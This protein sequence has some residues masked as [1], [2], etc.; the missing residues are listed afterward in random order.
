[1]MLLLLAF[2]LLCSAFFSLSEMA[3]VGLSKLRLRHMVGQ[4]VRNAATLD[5]LVKRIDDVIASL[6][7]ANN[8]VQSAVSSIGAALCIRWIG[9]EWGVLLATFLIG[10]LI[11]FF[12]EVT[13]KVLA[14]RRTD[15]VALWAAP[16][17]RV[18][19][20]VM[21]PTARIFISATNR[22][23]RLFGVEPGTRS[24]L[25]T[26][27]EIKIMIEVGKEQGVLGE[28]ERTLLHRIFEFGDLK[29]ADV[30]VPREKMVMVKEG[31]THEEVLTLLTEQG[32]SRIPVYRETPDKVIGIIYAQEMLH[33]WREG[34]LIV[35]HDLIHPPFEV[36]PD[37]RVSDLLREFQK[38]HLQIAIVVDSAGK[39]LGMVT[40]EDLIEEI[41]GELEERT[42]LGG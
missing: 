34:W 9:P 39:C 27:E 23:L 10:A 40:L 30:M 28:D 4:K 14:L 16:V 20:V 2:F 42:P 12:G 24:P 26:A 3:L 25:I 41:V 36:P 6:V 31:A 5:R 18:F 19:L 17:L 35:L 37:R 33:I 15:R 38:R 32:H 22:L 1:M 29:V 7:V 11:L 13:P 21:G 8:F